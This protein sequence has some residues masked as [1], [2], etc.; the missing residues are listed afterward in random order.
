MTKIGDV[1]DSTTAVLAGRAGMLAWIAALGFVLP[2][3]VQSATRLYGGGSPG[4][5][6]LAGLI[7]LAA[8]V[9]AL[10]GLLALIAVASDPAATLSRAGRLALARLPKLLLVALVAM[11]VSILVTLPPVVALAATGYDFTAASA[12]PDATGMP[13]MTPGAAGF[14]RLYS[15]VL[16]LLGLWVGARLS[17]LLPVVVNEGRGVGAFG[18]SWT[19]TRGLTWKLIGVALLFSLVYLVAQRAVQPVV[20][21]AAR[22]LL[23]PDDVATALFA[24]A[25]AGALVLA[26][27]M[28][29]VQVF[30]ARLYASVA[31]ARV[32]A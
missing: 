24:A 2:S 22:L 14:V 11:G 7:G 17:V 3:V 8:L 26:A 10:W 31:A 23:G 28:V 16:G 20:G 4:V 30:A 15:F 12:A 21:L 5:A 9:A 19:L 1:W 25:M 13:A 18:R 32:P 27:F 6:A 29:V